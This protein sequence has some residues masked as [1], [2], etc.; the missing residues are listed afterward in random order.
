MSKIYSGSEQFIKRFTID[1]GL[2]PGYMVKTEPHTIQQLIGW[3]LD[4]QKQRAEDGLLYFSGIV[5][6]TS[7]VYAFKKDGNTHGIHEPAARIEGEVSTEHHDEIFK[8]DLRL[9]E[10]IFDLA[11]FV[12]AKAEQERVH[13]SFESKYYVLEIKTTG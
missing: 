3:Y 6:P 9:L 13:I 4:W 12:G 5:V 7:F 2:L 1:L 8:D 10:I 11:Q